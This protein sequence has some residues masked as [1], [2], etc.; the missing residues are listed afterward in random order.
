[1]HK[2]R[3]FILIASAIGI[4][5]IF[6]PWVSVSAHIFGYSY[7]QS[8]NGFHGTGIV[9]FLGFLVT[10]AMP[11][12]GNKTQLLE[13]N[14]WLITLVAGALAFLF[15]LIFIISKSGT[16][17]SSGWGGIG[18]G[19]GVWL[20]L[21]ASIA[22]I[23]SAWLLKSSNNNLKKAFENLASNLNVS[24]TVSSTTLNHSGNDQTH[25]SQLNKQTLAELE[26]LAQMKNQGIIS[27]EEFQQLKSKLLNI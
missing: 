15:T 26:K 23:L 25:A 5:S 20:A 21:I 4:I 1:M 8:A 3:L 10:L 6:L 17:N 19:F 11:F 13:N 14:T 27:E 18:Y 2:Q 24:A 9:V 16:M 7:G 22:V 12:I